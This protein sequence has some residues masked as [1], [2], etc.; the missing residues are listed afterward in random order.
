METKKLSA[1]NNNVTASNSDAAVN[2]N[3][4]T[5][6]DDVESLKEII[7]KLPNSS[8]VTKDDREIILAAQAAYEA[9]SDDDKAAIDSFTGPN[10][11]NTNQPYGRI[12][13]SALWGLWSL[14]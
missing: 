7:S 14:E 5:A 13:E 8:D 9:L 12:L 2:E 11:Y 3:D 10:A 4:Q 1:V 6:E